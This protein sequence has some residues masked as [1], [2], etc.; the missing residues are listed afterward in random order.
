LIL[1]PNCPLP[2]PADPPRARANQQDW[3]TAAKKY[4]DDLRT[5]IETTVS[6]ATSGDLIRSVFGS[7]PYLTDL[8][9]ANPSTLRDFFGVG[10]QHCLNSILCQLKEKTSASTAEAMKELRQCKAQAALVIALADI[11]SLWN[12][13]QITGSLSDFADACVA[14][15][16]RTL[17]LQAHSQGA[18]NLTNAKHPELSSGY[19]V[20]GLGKL[21]ARELN[22]SS[23]IDLF[24]FYDDKHIPYS[25]KKTPQEFAIRLTKDLVRVLHERTAEGYVFRTDLRLRPDP[26][27][28]AVAVS[29]EAAQV[30]YES[31]GQNWERAALIKAR[32]IAGD[33]EIANSFLK[34]L[35]PFIWRKSLD[36]Y[37]IQDI[38][39]IKRQMYAHK[40]GSKVDV[41][42]H[43][44]KLG[45]G[46]I[47]EI[48]FYAQIQQLI[49]GG[50]FPEARA[51]Q[52]LKALGVLAELKF[53]SKKALHDLTQA[54]QFLRKLEHRLQMIS[55][56]QT[57][58]LPTDPA[59]LAGVATFFGHTSTDGFANEV[60]AILRSVEI[61]Y[62]D[63]FEDAPAL[64][65]DGNLVFTGTEDDPDTIST[66]Q[67]LGFQN[68]S[69]VI[70]TVRS[71]HHGRYRS[72]RSD[73][74][75]QILTEIMPN[76]MSA[77][78]KT[79]QPDAALVNFDRCLAALPAGVPILSV[80]YSNTKILELVGEIM[81]DAPRLAEHLSRRPALLDYVLE[82]EFYQPI[83][84]PKDIS[85]DLD[86]LLS[87]TD[88]FEHMLDACRRWANDL[89]F[90]VGV[91]CIRYLIDPIAAAET[92]TAIAEAVLRN[93]VPRVSDHFATQYG[94]IPGGNYALVGYGKLG[95]H[96]LT[97]TSDL[98][99]V[100]IYDAN[101]DDHSEGGPKS[102]PTPAY[103]MRLTQRIVTAFSSLTGEGRLYAID[104]R[105]RPSG[106]TGPLA[107]SVEAFKKY[108]SDDAWTWEHMALSRARVIFGDP[109]IKSKIEGV[110]VGVL[111]RSRDLHKLIRDVADMRN[112]I[113]KEN[114][115]DG[116]WDIKRRAGGLI[117]AEFVLQYLCLRY[118]E[119]GWSDSR[120]I[121]LASRLKS[122]GAISEQDISILLNGIQFWSRLQ[123]MLRL[124][125]DGNISD[126]DIPLG[127]RSKLAKVVDA[128]EFSD[129]EDLVA[130]T[131]DSIS[132]LYCKFIDDPASEIGKSK[133]IDQG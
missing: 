78:G 61:H 2:A 43:N 28:T 39:S 6:D 86:A 23:D 53:V 90:R 8:I 32:P 69:T 126:N 58:T 119:E 82:P 4:P 37:A 125:T 122:A 121:S 111:S 98:D 35:Q 113:R 92:L 49:W 7:S 88:A 93:I 42:G 123:F 57:Q 91:Q 112:R 11:A 132:A 12:L 110:V 127:L 74:A 105:L 1:L 25:G 116:Q 68:P 81:G 55:D 24:V 40:G 56:E 63:L 59:K 5:W 80:F 75:R 87:A 52:T 31:Y 96:E 66:L 108:Q 62:A 36:F 79:A 95:S 45:R 133:D 9:F 71:W 70:H 26:G 109:S 131:A 128:R 65:V 13:D 10:P 14:H 114:K 34:D 100:A 3:L 22:Y 130:K 97:P 47:R 120:P 48:E 50:R 41:A 44:I 19:V 15:A 106:D 77:F 64:T 103:Y 21:G 29:K 124:T 60:T 94:V 129:L 33:L 118:P 107:S 20:L 85:S 51:P 76:L 67:R 46:G 17:L 104:M 72:T 102:L 84:A 54:Y 101:L 16:V 115:K 83:A 117:D 30:Y 27:S 38:Q 18:I 99:L 89:Q 73:R